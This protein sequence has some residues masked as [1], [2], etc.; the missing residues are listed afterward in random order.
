[1]LCAALVWIDVPNI[2]ELRHL[3]NETGSWFVIVF[4]LAYVVLT[5]FPL[6]RTLWTIAA[7]IFFG[8]LVG[9]VVA[10]SALTVSAT[11][12]FL[13][14]RG[15]FGQWMRPHLSHPAVASLAHRLAQRGWLAV[16]SLRMVAG[17]PFSLLNYAAALS[18]IPLRQFVVATACGS[19]PTTIM[20]A[21]FGDALIGKPGLGIMG[22]FLLMAL[23]G[24]LGLIID[25][26]MPLDN[27]V[28]AVR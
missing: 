24:C 25:A 16:T 22:A 8:P 4:W 7:G 27:K 2:K 13:G 9:T 28:K 12:A 14:V 23:V 6:P 5:L 18:P 19:I 10:L 3:A 20:G 21:F 1:M 15:L 17:V 11:L 26:R